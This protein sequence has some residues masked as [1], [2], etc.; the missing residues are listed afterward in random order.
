MNR[1]DRLNRIVDYNSEQREREKAEEERLYARQREIDEAPDTKL[2][3]FFCERCDRD[4]EAIGFKGTIT[5]YPEHIAFYEAKC[6]KGHWTRRRITDQ[7]ND[8]YFCKSKVLARER[9]EMGDALLQP[10][11]P[12]FDS[13]YGWK[14]RKRESDRLAELERREWEDGRKLTK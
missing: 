11:D 3:D 8:P 6:P 13:V 9:A 12:R 10:D 7:Q 1:L 14:L 4:F 5:C 2:T